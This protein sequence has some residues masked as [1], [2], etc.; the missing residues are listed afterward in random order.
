MALIKHIR[1]KNDYSGVSDYSTADAKN[2]IFLS[3]YVVGTN[4]TINGV[5]YKTILSP[6][7]TFEVQLPVT[8]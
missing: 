6:R 7:F 4:V 5:L 1:K 8:C 2:N 3:F